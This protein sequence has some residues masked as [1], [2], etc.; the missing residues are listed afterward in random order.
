MKIFAVRIGTK[1]GSE[2]ETY[3]EERLPEYDFHWIREPYY[4]G[5]QL[6]W[7]KMWVM[8]L[9]IDEP[10]CVMDIDV[11][12]VSDYKKVF[13]YPIERGEFVAMPGWWRDTK[14]EGYSLNGGFFKY[15]PIDCNYIYEKFMSDINYWQQYY[16]KNGVTK[17]PVNGEQYFVEDSVKEKLTLKLLPNEWFT[18]WVVDET[19]NY[20]K[21]MNRWQGQ[22]TSKYRKLTGNDYIYLG[23]EFHP[24]IKF[25]HFTH[26][27]NKP[28]EWKDYDALKYK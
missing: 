6:Q 17:G 4:H 5:V 16:I 20:G 28:H 10:V 27:L 21:N 9:D 7:N 13:D 1:Y 2:Y 19:I 12:L 8:S 26:S 23:G 11:L 3:L 15:H 24:D 22:I 14:K 18:R 25:V